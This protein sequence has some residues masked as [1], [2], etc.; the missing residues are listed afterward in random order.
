[1]KPLLTVNMDLK[2]KD[3]IVNHVLLGVGIS[4]RGT[5]NEEDKGG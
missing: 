3:R 5:V 4:R 2:M 1:M